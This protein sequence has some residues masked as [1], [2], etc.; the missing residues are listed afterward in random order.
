MAPPLPCHQQKSYWPY[1]INWPLLS[2]RPMPFHFHETGENANMLLFSRM[3]TRK[4]FTFFSISLFNMLSL[5]THDIV[6]RHIA[7]SV[8]G[9]PNSKNII[10]S[11]THIDYQS[12]YPPT[13]PYCWC[14][15]WD[16][17]G[18]VNGDDEGAG[19]WLNTDH[20]T[21]HWYCFVLVCCV[22]IILTWW[23]WTSM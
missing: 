9:L 16:G 4:C 18:K 2:T 8:L 3:N 10:T 19:Q 20:M 6:P 5:V 23:G 22:L 14:L 1:R 21:G 12:Q 7:S 15:L 13:K 17:E 11:N